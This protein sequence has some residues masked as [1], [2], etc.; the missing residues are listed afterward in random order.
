MFHIIKKRLVFFLVTTMIF[1]MSVCF[2][3]AMRFNGWTTLIIPGEL[4]FQIPPTMEVQGESYKELMKLYSP[5]TYRGSYPEGSIKLMAQQKG[6]TD[7]LYGAKDHFV[8]VT[9]QVLTDDNEPQMPE[10]GKPLGLTAN[11][12]AVYEEIVINE[13]KNKFKS[14][15]ALGRKIQ[16]LGVTKHAEIVYIDGKEALHYAFNSQIDG[17]PIVYNDEYYFFNRNKT[18]RIKKKIRSTEYAYWTQSGADVRNVVR[19]LQP[20]K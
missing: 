13:L 16:F 11:D 7:G 17:Y 3:D 20:L 14:I 2:A 5:E 12:L 1:T 15:N 8:R 10:F 19:T 9:V 6:L 4:E 18:Y